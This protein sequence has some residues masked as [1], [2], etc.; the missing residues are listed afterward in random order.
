[1]RIQKDCRR[2]GRRQ[3]SVPSIE[4]THL[5]KIGWNVAGADAK[6][7]KPAKLNGFL[8][9]R[10]RKDRDG[11]PV[12]DYNAMEGLCYSPDNIHEA[13]KKLFNAPDECLPD[14]LRFII[15]KDAKRVDGHWEYPETLVASYQL[16]GEN[17]RMCVGN[18]CTAER[19][20][21]D[22]SQ[23]TIPCVPFGKIGADPKDF[24][25][26]S[27]PNAPKNKKCNDK[28]CFGGCLYKISDGKI[29]P[30]FPGFGMNSLAVLETTS[31]YCDMAAFDHFDEVADR[32]GGNLCG[33]TGTLRFG[34]R[35]RRTGEGASVS[36]A[37]VGHV[38]IRIDEE[39]VLRRERELHGDKLIGR[40]EVLSISS[41]HPVLAIELKQPQDNGAIYPEPEY[42]EFEDAEETG[43][44]VEQPKAAAQGDKLWEEADGALAGGEETAPAQNDPEKAEAIDTL[45]RASEA[46]GIS[47]APA[48]KKAGVDTPWDLDMDQIRKLSAWVSRKFDERQAAGVT[49]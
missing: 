25:P 38:F 43:A 22:G 26:F 11:R 35:G 34:K 49:K 6:Y 7:P 15:T 48:L 33:L 37:V 4:G 5:I 10:N 3:E 16:Y 28:F 8:L 12:I 2:F 36:K 17:G 32:L 19:K 24:C 13:L 14:T 44:V 21:S 29:C 20:Q 30:V 18:G 27:G 23:K 40:T 9:C 39:A 42:A 45:L 47:L 46:T 41:G 1:M 31:E